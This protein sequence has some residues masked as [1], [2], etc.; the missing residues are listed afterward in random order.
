MTKQLY[1]EDVTEDM[2]IPNLVKH[3]TTRQLVK[4]AGASGDFYEV[5][6]DKDFAQ[7][8]GLPGVIVHGWLGFSFLAQMITDWIG[9]EGRLKK[10]GVS[11]RGMHL[12]GQDVICKGRVTKKYTQDG[13]NFVECEIWAE[14]AEGQTTTPG[15]CLVSLPSKAK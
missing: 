14:N 3:P 13:E 12:P 2:E 11:Y 15:T 10:I 7:S 9:V 8:M 1:H 6:Y 5:H 4:W